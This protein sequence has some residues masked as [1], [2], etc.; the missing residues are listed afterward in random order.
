M[1]KKSCHPVVSESRQHAR[2]AGVQR[3]AVIQFPRQPYLL[4]FVRPVKQPVSLSPRRGGLHFP[5]HLNTF[6]LSP[7]FVVNL[8]QSSFSVSPPAPQIPVRSPDTVGLSSQM[9]HSC[10]PFC[11]NHIADLM[12]SADLLWLLSDLPCCRWVVHTLSPEET[13]SRSRNKSVLVA[14]RS[15]ANLIR[16]WRK[17]PNTPIS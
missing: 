6:P 12:Q 2:L 14:A 8:I 17:T 10:H 16:P 5:L 13:N 9:N 11:R 3:E 15:S 1:K 4:P 7:F